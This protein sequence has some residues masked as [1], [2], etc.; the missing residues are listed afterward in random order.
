MLT[1]TQIAT[2]KTFVQNSSAPEIV[3]ARTAGATFLL[4]GLLNAANNPV[5]KAWRV[6][7]SAVELDDAADYTGFD[8]LNQGKRDEWSIFLQYAPRDMTKGAKRK[9]V[10]DVWGAASAGT[11]AEVILTACLENAT[12]A[13]VAIGGSD[14][15]TGTVT[16]LKRNFTELVDQ[17]DCQKILA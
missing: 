13:Q 14:A 6:A 9:V 4:M 7:V 10:T 16:A 11:N 3:A 17:D 1:P 2:L 12:V 8:T 15:S 5:T